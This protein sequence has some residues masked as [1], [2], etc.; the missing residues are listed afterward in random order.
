MNK[1]N[2]SRRKYLRPKEIEE[3]FGISW[4]IVRQKLRESG[5]LTNIVSASKGTYIPSRIAIDCKIAW[6]ET[7]R[8][9]SYGWLRTY[10]EQLIGDDPI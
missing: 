5:L 9:G 1:S 6:R 3:V 10:I 7:A 2:L 8:H 4:T